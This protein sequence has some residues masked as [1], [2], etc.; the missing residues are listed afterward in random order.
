[1]R[2]S[3]FWRPSLSFWGGRFCSVPIAESVRSV[4]E[5]SHLSTEDDTGK[6]EG[7][8]RKFDITN[9]GNPATHSLWV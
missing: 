7:L 9:A 2:G 4:Y 8:H 3:S 1:M 6:I 5:K